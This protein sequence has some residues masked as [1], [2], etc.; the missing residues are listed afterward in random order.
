VGSPHFAFNRRIV[1]ACAVPVIGRSRGSQACG[2]AA[3]RSRREGLVAES[4]AVAGNANTLTLPRKRAVEGSGTRSADHWGDA[5]SIV[6][7]WTNGDGSRD[8]PF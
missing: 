4:E 2:E 6:G 5:V 1:M 8:K 7:T 3:W